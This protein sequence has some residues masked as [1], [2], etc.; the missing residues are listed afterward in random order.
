MVPRPIGKYGLL[1]LS[2]TVVG[3]GVEPARPPP[4]SASEYRQHQWR[5]YTVQGLAWRAAA[6]DGSSLLRIL[7]CCQPVHGLVRPSVCLSVCPSIRMSVR[8][9]QAREH[10]VNILLFA[11]CTNIELRNT[12]KCKRKLKIRNYMKCLE[13]NG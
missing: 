5:I 12:A 2:C 10:D 3:G 13:G 6:T 9:F 7:R 1:K 4:K 8:S 11:K